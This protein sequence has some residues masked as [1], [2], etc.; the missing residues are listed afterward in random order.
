MPAHSHPDNNAHPHISTPKLQKSA[1]WTTELYIISEKRSITL[2]DAGAL[3]PAAWS[4][5]LQDK[6]L[7]VLISQKVI[8][9]KTVIV[10]FFLLMLTEWSWDP[11]ECWRPMLNLNEDL[12]NNN[13]LTRLY[14]WVSIWEKTHE[15]RMKLFF[16]IDLKRSG[17]FFKTRYK[18]ESL[19][20]WSEK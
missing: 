16:L 7:M 10:S 13:N 20:L 1:D 9:E 19:I 6:L 5:L 18:S 3:N 12:R 8:D 11:S 4:F 14:F 2:Q 17:F 15:V